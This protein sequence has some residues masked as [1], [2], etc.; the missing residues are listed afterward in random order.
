MNNEYRVSWE[1]DIT[2]D[3]PEEAAV[4]AREIQ[5]SRQSTTNV[6]DVDDRNWPYRR[7]AVDLE[8]VF[9]CDLCDTWFTSGV[10]TCEHSRLCATCTP[11]CDACKVS[12]AA[13]V[14]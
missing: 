11:S 12:M 14:E 6:F 8:D 1:I 5:L 9:Q 4:N 13:G 7:W 3:S 10:N 2:A